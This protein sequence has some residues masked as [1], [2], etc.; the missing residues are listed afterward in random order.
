MLV[1]TE[2]LAENCGEWRL[3]RNFM[4]IEVKLDEHDRF[5]QR[6]ASWVVERSLETPQ[7]GRPPYSQDELPAQVVRK[8][9]VKSVEPGI[10]PVERAKPHRHPEELSREQEGSDA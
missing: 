1:D 3:P 8:P 9:R 5:C 7:V 10:Q 6:A 2:K 4:L